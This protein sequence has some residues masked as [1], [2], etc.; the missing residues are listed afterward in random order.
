MTDITL[1]RYESIRETAQRTGVS[2]KTVRRYIQRGRFK[3][4]RIGRLIRLDPVQVDIALDPLS[5]AQRT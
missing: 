4:Y 3:V 5:D 2:Q 1:R